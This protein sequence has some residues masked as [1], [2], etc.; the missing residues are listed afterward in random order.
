MST[1]PKNAENYLLL[2]PELA[3]SVGAELPTGTQRSA[4]VVVTDA[5]SHWRTDALGKRLFWQALRPLVRAL[6]LQQG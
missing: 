5:P 4:T 1:V 2:G 6:R 3:R